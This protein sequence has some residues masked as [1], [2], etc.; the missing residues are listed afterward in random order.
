MIRRRSLNLDSIHIALILFFCFFNLDQTI[1][2]QEQCCCGADEEVEVP[3]GDFE[4]SPYPAPGGWID[5]TSGFGPW[6]VSF[7][8][9]SHHDDGHNNLGNGNPNPSTAHVDLNGFSPG[10]ICQTINGFTVGSECTLTFFYA[11]HNGISS[12]EATV[13]LEGGSVLNETWEAD[14]VGSN[15][16]LEAN[17]SFTAT[18]T[19]MELCFE[20]LV[21]VNCCGM[22]IDDISFSCCPTDAE[23]PVLDQMPQDL[24]VMCLDDVPED[25]DIKASDDCTVDLEVEFNEEIEEQGCNYVIYRDWSVEDDCGKISEYT[26]VISV[27]DDES[28]EVLSPPEDLKIFCNDDILEVFNDWVANYG[29]AVIDENCGEILVEVEHDVIDLNSCSQTLVTFIYSDLCGHSVEENAFFE[30]DDRSDPVFIQ[31]PSDLIIPC[32]SSSVSIIDNWLANNAGSLAM[33]DCDFTIVND[34]TGNYD[35]TDIVSFIAMDFCGNANTTIAQIIYTGNIDTIRID[36]TTCDPSIAGIFEE[37]IDSPTTCDSLIIL[38]IE[39][40]PSDTLELTEYSCDPQEVGFDTLISSNLAG[41]D[42]I[43]YLQTMLLRSDTVMLFENVCD[44]SQIGTD[45]LIF[46]NVQ[47]CDSLVYL[48]ILVADSDTLNIIKQTCDSTQ[49][50]IDTLIHQNIQGCDSIVYLHTQYSSSDTIYTIGYSCDIESENYDTS[51]IPGILCDTIVILQTIPLKDDT[52]YLFEFDCDI[53]ETEFLTEVLA[54]MLCDSI[55]ITEVIPLAK[56]TSYIISGSCRIQD[57]G[58]D[59]SYYINENGCDSLVIIDVFYEPIPPIYVDT[60]SC[61]QQNIGL[62]TMMIFSLECD[63]II[64][65]NT[66]LLESSETVIQEIS[67]ETLPNDTLL[68]S[69]SDGCDSLVII[70]YHFEEISF[71]YEL[72]FDPCDPFSPVDLF[73]FNVE[74]GTEPYQYILNS[75]ITSDMPMITLQEEGAY[76]IL[77]QDA[78]GCI[79]EEMIVSLEWPEELVINLPSEITILNGQPYPLNITLPT[80]VDSFYWSH[81]EVLSCTDCLDLV[82]Y[83]DEDLIL[84]L[85]VISSD[86]CLSLRIIHI[87][88]KNS[89]VYIPNIFSPNGDKVNDDFGIFHSGS[90]ELIHSFRIYDR[91]GNLVF[92]KLDSKPDATSYWNGRFNNSLVDPNVFVYHFE[93]M[94][95]NGELKTFLGEILVVK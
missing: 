33:D 80:N 6:D 42:S 75:N 8:S 49:I 37:F 69:N 90:V 24:T 70:E 21:T 2:A 22:L 40:N 87:K 23:E 79:S 53:K 68:F 13:S 45:T 83:S 41:C 11:I 9:I 43:V 28:P 94:M 18:S 25:P 46:Q 31:V 32:D 50:G 12:G 16:W 35:S 74:G 76:S 36:S 7:G 44:S 39:F 60:Y 85:H 38:N 86:G 66:H 5:Y 48:H 58:I 63:S 67:C 65:T 55:V 56:D 64:I 93:L 84:E 57:L 34:F 54:G 20:S 62:D 47:G 26:Q 51:S 72:E 52:T 89:G 81:P 27:I 15:E 29:F 59:T 17:Y 1:S 77:I 61:N 95:K 73:I 91:W 78:E 82:V 92:E 14:N 19:S 4:F 30:V 88:I 71:D 10:G 3:G